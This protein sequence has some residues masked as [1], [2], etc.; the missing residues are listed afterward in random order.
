MLEN[1]GDNESYSKSAS[2][3]AESPGK[4][5]STSEPSINLN[6]YL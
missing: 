1:D 4:E 2:V 3:T 6:L 5:S